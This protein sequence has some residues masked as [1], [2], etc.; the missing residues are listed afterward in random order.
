MA[1]SCGIAIVV[2]AIAL[3]FSTPV[4]GNGKRGTRVGELVGPLSSC[5]ISSNTDFYQPCID[6]RS[7]CVLDSTGTG[8]YVCQCKTGF[9]PSDDFSKCIN[10]A[11]VTLNATECLDDS[12]CARTLSVCRA[13][14]IIPTA[15]PGGAKPTVSSTGRRC[16]CPDD[17]DFDPKTGTCATAFTASDGCYQRSGTPYCRYRNPEYVCS[18]STATTTPNS[19]TCQ[20]PAQFDKVTLACANPALKA[21]KGD[22]DCIDVK[23]DTGTSTTSTA[24]CDTKTGK[25]V[26]VMKAQPASP[27]TGP[28]VV[29]VI[30]QGTPGFPTYAPGLPDFKCTPVPVQTACTDNTNCAT[31]LQHFCWKAL[32][33]AT[34]GLCMCL[35]LTRPAL[36]GLLCNDAFGRCCNPALPFNTYQ[37]GLPINPLPIGVSNLSCQSGFCGCAPGT[38]YQAQRGCVTAVS[39]N[40]ATCNIRS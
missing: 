30:P 7:T 1:F 24:T 37:C 17:K 20:P 21:C 39:S 22:N 15:V 10:D 29:P 27:N 11:S 31:G 2:L 38:T 18:S 23:M 32:S 6:P 40:G 16:Q 5:S 14:R 25:C 33:T 8:R 13:N 28:A 12:D 9:E 36:N 19:C 26:C 4:F 35:P 34:S 3:I